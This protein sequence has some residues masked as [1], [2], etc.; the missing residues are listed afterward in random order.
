MEKSLSKQPEH[1]QTFFS[2]GTYSLKKNE[3]D[4]FTEIPSIELSNETGKKFKLE[5]NCC[6]NISTQKI[7]CI[8]NIYCHNHPTNRRKLRANGM[9]WDK[10][11][12]KFSKVF[13]TFKFPLKKIL[14]IT[15][16]DEDFEIWHTD[17]YRFFIQHH[18]SYDFKSEKFDLDLNVL[19]EFLN[20][21]YVHINVNEEPRTVGGGVLE[22]AG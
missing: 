7:P 16:H 15:V 19:Q 3:F 21:S 8:L 22:P 1:V 17:V 6:L 14:V 20:G 9:E 12:L 13:T 4:L 11:T 10:K 5:H 18:V 2:K